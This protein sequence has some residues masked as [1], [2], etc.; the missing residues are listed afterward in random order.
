[1]RLLFSTMKEKSF[2]PLII[3]RLLFYTGKEKSFPFYYIEAANLFLESQSRDIMY[4]NIAK[5]TSACTY[6]P[7]VSIWK[8]FI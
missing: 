3:S 5:L 2:S 7:Q 8:Q 6:D 4:A 1:M